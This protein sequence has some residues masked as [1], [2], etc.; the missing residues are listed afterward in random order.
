MIINTREGAEQHGICGH[1]CDPLDGNNDFILCVESQMS[2]LRRWRVLSVLIHFGPLLLVSADSHSIL[3]ARTRN[4]ARDTKRYVTAQG[5]R[6]DLGALKTRTPSIVWEISASEGLLGDRF[7]GWQ[8]SRGN[9][10]DRLLL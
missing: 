1:N 5:S 6:Q 9:V 4:R 7:S 8:F 10:E 2:A 3:E